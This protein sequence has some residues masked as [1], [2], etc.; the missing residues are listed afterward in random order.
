MCHDG[1]RVWGA[2]ETREVVQL[3]EGD[4]QRSSR[5]GLPGGKP[6]PLFRSNAKYHLYHIL[7]VCYEIYRLIF[8]SC[9]SHPHSVT[10]DIFRSLLVHGQSQTRGIKRLS[11]VW[12]LSSNV[13]VVV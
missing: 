5:F 10:Q 12:T 9:E 7:T 1:L 2:T 13:D 8:F 11:L 3:I 4:R 6:H